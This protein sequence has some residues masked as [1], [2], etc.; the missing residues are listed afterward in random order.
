MERR[1]FLKNTAFAGMALHLPT[2][3]ASRSLAGPKR[4]VFVYNNWSAYDE[5]SDKVVQTEALAMR[6]L[7]EIVRLKQ[8]GVRIDYYV[9]DAFWFDK[10]GGYRVWHKEHWP[11]GPSK[12]L[13]ACKAHGIRPGMWFS[14]NL[15]ATHDGRFLEPVAAWGDSVA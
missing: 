2:V 6:E 10:N 3:L 11:Q 13:A 7:G 5:L 4:P 8:S 12:W 9:M 15:I 1:T 14:T